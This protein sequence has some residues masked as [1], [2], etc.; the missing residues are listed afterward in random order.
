MNVKK[1]ESLFNE[2][3]HEL[4]ARADAMNDYVTFVVN[5]HINYTD[6]CEVRCPLCAFSN[7]RGYTMSV[8]EIVEEAVK[9]EKSGA[10]EVHI[11]GGLNPELGIEYFEEAFRRIKERTGLTIKALT[12]SEILYYARKERTS[13]REFLSRL[14]DVGLAALPGGGAEILADD[15]RRVISP[16]KC[17]SEEW[18]RVMRIAHELGLKSNAT[19]LFGHVESIKHRALHLYRL[20]KLQE[21]TGGFVSFIPLPFHPENTRLKARGLVRD[22]TGV[23]DILRTIAVSRI[24]LENFRS[25]RAY[26]V[27]LGEN[28]ASVALRYGANDL[29]GTVMGEKIGHA[30][31]AKSPT[32]LSVERL[33]RIAKAS[34][35]RVAQRDTFCNVLRWF[36]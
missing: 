26:W 27:L 16:R 7:R 28:L 3:L 31:G 15:V 14:R 32:Q 13:V 4:G 19:M 25:V 20:R 24:V 18:L 30:A 12:A 9:A 11:V 36:D 10:T 21:K 6:V 17:S 5:K 23:A 29:D 33:V 1:I 2:P 34:G 35:K 22:R 8:D